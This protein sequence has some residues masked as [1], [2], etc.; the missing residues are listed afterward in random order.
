MSGHGRPSAYNKA[1]RRFRAL[2]A[3]VIVVLLVL[4]ACTQ[5]AR[6]TFDD[7]LRK[8]AAQWLADRF[9][10]TVVEIGRARWCWPTGFE[11]QQV[12]LC[13][14]HLDRKRG[15]LLYA[16]SIRLWLDG[17]WQLVRRG[18]AAI[19]HVL[20]Q[21]GQVQLERFADGSW[22]LTQYWAGNEDERT[23]PRTVWKGCEV[24]LRDGARADQPP[25][26]LRSA[27]LVIDST[28]SA[29]KPALRMEFR[30]VPPWANALHC[31]AVRRQGHWS[32]EMRIAGLRLEPSLWNG[33]P[34][35]WRRSAQRLAGLRAEADV[36][37][38]LQ[39]YPSRWQY[40]LEAQLR[41]GW[42]ADAR[43]PYPLTAVRAEV[44]L[45][46]GGLEI[47]RGTARSAGADIEFRFSQPRWG[48][49]TP[50]TFEVSAKR[51]PLDERLPN[52]LPAFFQALWHKY[53]PKGLA[54]VT[55]RL[56]YDGQRYDVQ[57]VMDLSDVAF[58][59]ER[60]PYR[61]SRGKGRLQWKNDTLTV[62][63]QVPVSGRTASI[64]GQ[65]NM[66]NGVPAGWI[67]VQTDGPIPLD[68]ELL[69]ALP[70]KTEQFVRSLNATGMFDV[71]ARVERTSADPTFRKR[72]ELHVENG[73]L[74]YDRFPYPLERL[75]GSITVEDDRVWISRLTG[76]NDSGFIIA[77]GRWDPAAPD[78]AALQLHLQCTDVPLHE[79]LRAALSPSVQRLW[80]GLQPQGTVDRLDATIVFT[81]RTR[82]LDIEVSGEK[83]DPQ[84]NVEGRTIS[85]RPRWLPLRWDNVTGKF[86]YRQ[87]EIVFE[88]VHAERG[89]TRIDGLSGRWRADHQGRWRLELDTVEWI[90]LPWNDELLAALP[91]ALRQV[92]S[93]WNFQGVVHGGG[94]ATLEGTPAQGVTQAEWRGKLDTEDARLTCGWRWEHI[95]GGVEI[96]GAFRH[97]MAT[98]D[99]ELQVDSVVLH[100]TQVTRL[101]GPFSWNGGV[102][103]LGTA[104]EYPHHKP[105]TPPVTARL[106][107]GDL[108]L[109]A[110]IDG[111]DP[112][113]FTV[114]GR[115]RDADLAQVVGYVGGNA[116]AASGKLFG[117]LSLRG[118]M[119][120]VESWRGSGNVQFFQANVYQLPVMVALLKL[121]NVR[122]PD[123]TAFT[124][125]DMQFRCEGDRLVF[126]RL[127]LQGDAI[128][129]VGTGSVTFQRQLDLS[130]Y[131]LVGR[132]D[133]Q[134]P[135]FR[136]LF[137]QAARNV[138]L[139]DVTGSLD[140]PTLAPRPFPELNATLQQ[141]LVDIPQGAPGV[142]P[143]R[144]GRTNPPD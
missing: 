10:G 107:G 42:L 73:T 32:V 14:P 133:A 143:P 62:E 75:R 55:V 57:S 63:L 56:A 53:S 1:L 35:P 120:I 30:A 82:Q 87:G 86:W 108:E 142:R 34:E 67:E 83:W 68:E 134:W 47:C 129:M 90:G 81:P 66:A 130:F 71:W 9:P 50:F 110:A 106:F 144:T 117:E 44:R 98:C 136:P 22:N 54:D 112:P 23:L 84:Q 137:R 61:V 101:R 33:L 114:H 52:M 39:G 140:Q 11:L 45:T 24:W 15:T 122:P 48:D 8:E 31:T 43:L 38:A 111:G 20:I 59:Y 7:Q 97:G 91:A 102:L 40:T 13:E 92:L 116:D 28:Q 4:V 141:L 85:I 94:K 99:G 124:T 96:S 26:I 65:W 121:L 79:S 126:D 135:L 104:E 80:S 18:G 5:L 118:S 113:Q 78:G 88:N 25:H 58:V 16:E 100:G 60:F 115:L 138:L 77:H 128:S 51:L 69:V 127:A 76:R 93:R 49:N 131:T 109:Q 6:Q 19:R 105:G 70:D 95:R 27:R 21:G 12:R 125:G 29:G 132:E 41:D 123:T 74:R 36:N 64:H 89:A 2:V 119:G 46:N 72:V 139:I 103:S 17:P 3:A 37:L